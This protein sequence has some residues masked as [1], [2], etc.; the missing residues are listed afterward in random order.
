[1]ATIDGQQRKMVVVMP[2][3]GLSPAEVASLETAFHNNVVD[4]LKKSGK[5]ELAHTSPRIIVN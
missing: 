1:M 3:L 4:V 5:S 2:D